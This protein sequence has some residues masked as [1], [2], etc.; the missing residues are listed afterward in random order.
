[1]SSINNGTF[2]IHSVGWTDFKTPS[3]AGQQSEDQ[4]ACKATPA[5]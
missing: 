1:M 3:S 4:N 2:S 5:S